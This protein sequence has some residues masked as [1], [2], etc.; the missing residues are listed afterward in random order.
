M[1]TR[2][3]VSSVLK[4]VS[5]VTMDVMMAEV[6]NGALESF[7]RRQV[8]EVTK[9]RIFKIGDEYEVLVDGISVQRKR[10]NRPIQLQ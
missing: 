6:H 3:Q 5:S 8:S 1:F 7:D 10:K 2:R 9:S 4:L